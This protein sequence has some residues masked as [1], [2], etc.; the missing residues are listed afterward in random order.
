VYV[1]LGNVAG[2]T[3]VKVN[4]TLCAADESEESG[5]IKLI[6]NGTDGA[7]TQKGGDQYCNDFAAMSGTSL[8]TSLEVAITVVQ[9][10]I[11]GFAFMDMNQDGR[12]TL[13]NNA[14]A[15]LPNINVDLYET[16]NDG[17]FKLDDNNQ[18]I[19]AKDVMGNEIK[20]V[21]T[22][23]NGKYTFDNVAPGN[24]MIV[25]TDPE[26]DYQWKTGQ[27]DF[28]ELAVSILPGEDSGY[29]QT[30]SNVNR[31]I[32]T[33]SNL[34]DTSSSGLVE[35]RIYSPVAMPAK[36]EMKT[37]TVVSTNNNVG[38]YCIEAKLVKH[39]TGMV[40][41]VPNGASLTYHLDGVTI[42]DELQTEVYT[43][44]ITI[45]QGESYNSITAV[46]AS[47]GPITPATVTM[48]NNVNTAAYDWTVGPFYLRAKD[49]SGNNITYSFTETVS[50]IDLDLYDTQVVTKLDERTGQTIFEATNHQRS[51]DFAFTKVDAKD[52]TGLKD[53]KFQF[54]LGEKVLEFTKIADGSY[55][56]SCDNIDGTE[57]RVTQVQ[58]SNNGS[59]K[60]TGLPEGTLTMKETKAPSGYVLPSGSW[61]IA[62]T[63]DGIH[64]DGLSGTGDQPAIAIKESQSSTNDAHGNPIT[65]TSYEYMV[66]NI[67]H[68]GIPLTG[69][70]GIGMY[71]ITGLA[72]TVAGALLLLEYRR[73]KRAMHN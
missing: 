67:E 46:R 8:M 63:K 61:T 15:V 58:V 57:D 68:V 45:T 50:G 41:E 29:Y 70:D 5:E 27:P 33:Y 73:R 39:W 42:V 25:F 40:T 32:A 48:T 56:V 10:S 38:F 43:E 24:F 65:I 60:L 2:Q 1:S 54:L 9:R 72:I 7:P 52:E 53:A 6:T 69:A 14:D 28:S 12:F 71:L 59:L 35:A 37:A 49:A 11:T 20:T 17:S 13:G 36:G 21:L 47:N 66:P 44:D 64:N 55:R 18:R 26:N 31:C 22:D 51:H 62:V 19:H 4:L 30:A 23:Q 16:G 3:Y 34:D